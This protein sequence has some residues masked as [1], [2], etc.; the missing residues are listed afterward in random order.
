MD[1]DSVARI[2]EARAVVVLTG[3]GM[4]AE[5]GVP[6]FRGPGGLWRRYRPEELATPEAFARDPVLVWEWYDWRR[7]TVMAARPHA[8]HTALA[9]LESLLPRVT[10]VTQNV[11]GLHQRAGSRRVVELHG[12]ILRARCVRDGS[13]HRDLAVPLPVIPPRCDCGSLLRPDVVWFGESLPAAAVEE[14][15]QETAAAEV[16]LVVGTSS[17]VYPAA[18]LPGAAAEAGAWVAEINPEATPLSTWAHASWRA[19]AGEILPALVEAL[20]GAAE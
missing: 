7:Q 1:A 18:G 19:R 5:S 10:V 12:S 3:A 6:T 2:R 11:D 20:G 15:F 14:A 16:V 4:S 17:L 13:V 9:R 8:G